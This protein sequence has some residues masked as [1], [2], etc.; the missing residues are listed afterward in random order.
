V[1]A[2]GT[3]Q[4]ALGPLSDRY[5][6][7]PVLLGGLAAFAL[8]AV[9]CAFVTNV[10]VLVALRFIQGLAASAGTVCAR[11]IVADVTS[12]RAK[13]TSLQ[14]YIS[15]T[16]SLAPILAP[17]AGVA[18]LAFFGWRWLYA[19]LAIAGVG[20]ILAVAFRLPETSPLVA[21]GVRAGYARVFSTSKT[22]VFA[23][24]IFCAFAGYFALISSSSLVLERQ[25]HLT[26]TFFALAFA[27]NA[28][29]TMSGSFLAAKL[30]ARIGSDR[31]L[32]AGVTLMLAASVAALFVNMFAPSA[33]GFTITMAAFAFTYG[34]AVPGAF[35]S[36]LS[37]AGPD[38]GSTSAILGSMQMV[39]GA[40]GS[41]VA[42][43][44]PS[45]SVTSRSSSSVR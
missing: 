27:A 16:N 21:R 7:R 4:L 9:G 38:A 15:V 44:L 31:L 33:A 24:L 37:Q 35:A 12:D 2:F 13:A 1:L 32:Q 39:G 19:G 10:Y 34:L 43:A 6:R 3:G 40:L 29:A 5:G 18:I 23:G 11:A 17:I 36:A 25:L 8:L 28:L 26:A 14:A 41:A 20:L 22:L 45:A 42:A 30:A